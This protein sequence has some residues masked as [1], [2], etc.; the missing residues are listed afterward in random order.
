MASLRHP[1]QLFKLRYLP[2]AVTLTSLALGIFAIISLTQGR[3]TSAVILI[4]IASLCDLAD[5][6]LARRLKAHSSIGPS[7][8]SLA[9]MVTFGTAPA[10]FIYY[11]ISQQHPSSLLAAYSAAI[12][13]ITGALRLARFNVTAPIHP[14][15]FQGLPIPAAALIIVTTFLSITIGPL[16]LSALFVTIISCLMV[17]SLPYVKF[18]SV[19]KLP[20]VTWGLISIGLGILIFSGYQIYL[21]LTVT[22]IYLISG[23]IFSLFKPSPKS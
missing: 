22:A 7:L 4:T 15:F 19:T 2:N 10:L 12:F 5:G 20:P 23:P 3:L 9:D 13:A 21:P 8:D 17:S 1:L 18:L 6:H 14:G 16:A 11:I